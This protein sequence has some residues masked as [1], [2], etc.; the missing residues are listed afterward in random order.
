MLNFIETCVTAFVSDL[1]EKINKYDSSIHVDIRNSGDANYLD[2]FSNYENDKNYAK[3]VTNIVVLPPNNITI[4]SDKY[5]A[6]F[7]KGVATLVDSEF[8]T[9]QQ[10]DSIIR[11]IPMTLN[12]EIRAETPDIL[13]AYSLFEFIISNRFPTYTFTFTYLH[14][15]ITAVVRIPTNIS[16]D[17]AYGE[18]DTQTPNTVK[19][20]YDM[21]VEVYMPVMAR[22]DKNDKTEFVSSNNVIKHVTH[23]HP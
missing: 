9:Q 11:N 22:Y 21:E 7:S 1:R 19:T 4:E 8:D 17:F 10:Y 2:E 12:L 6:K 13:Q 15:N 16:V 3:K 14:I 5:I 20:P 18:F 23:N